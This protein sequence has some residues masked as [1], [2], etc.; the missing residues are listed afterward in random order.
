[1]VISAR[2]WLSVRTQIA[3]DFAHVTQYPE[4]GDC[5]FHFLAD[6]VLGQLEADMYM[7]EQI[8]GHM[9]ENIDDYAAYLGTDGPA[10]QP[11]AAP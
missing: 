8:V 4:D 6:V 9:R 1:M 11:A 7:R 5:L 10:A 2:Y 3:Q